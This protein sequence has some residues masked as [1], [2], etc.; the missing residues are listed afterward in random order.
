[1]IKFDSYYDLIFRTLSYIEYHSDSEITMPCL[2][3]RSIEI[4][5][6]DGEI[7]HIWK[8]FYMLSI[9]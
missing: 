3:V 9:M 5:L 2:T 7:M 1:M 8:L 6:R 4:S